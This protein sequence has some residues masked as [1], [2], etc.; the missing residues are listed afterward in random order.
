MEA[1]V[2]FL[3]FHFIF[4]KSPYF[5]LFITMFLEVVRKWKIPVG[6]QIMTVSRL[7]H[8]ILLGSI[9]VTILCRRCAEYSAIRSLQRKLLD[10]IPFRRFTQSEDITS[11]RRPVISWTGAPRT[12][13]R[14]QN[15]SV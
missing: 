2:C 10:K 4:Q 3:N 7:L 13:F 1:E 5:G 8:L 11:L 6:K 12:Q 14:Y 9:S 15:I